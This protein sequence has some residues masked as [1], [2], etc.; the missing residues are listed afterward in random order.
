MLKWWVVA[1]HRR[2]VGFSRAK[3]SDTER[4]YIAATPEELQRINDAI[5]Q[6]LRARQDLA[7]LA[8]KAGLSLIGVRL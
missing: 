1:A 8:A 5:D 7:C 4:E 6:I 3:L 2:L